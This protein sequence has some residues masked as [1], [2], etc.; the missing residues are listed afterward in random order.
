MRLG[1]TDK[2]QKAFNIFGKLLLGQRKDMEREPSL[3]QCN[4]KSRKPDFKY[5][6]ELYFSPYSNLTLG[7]H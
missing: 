2:D 3:S 7:I 4:N 6:I 1:S 5:K